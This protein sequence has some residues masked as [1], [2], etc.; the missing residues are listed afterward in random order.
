MVP[1]SRKEQA[2]RSYFTTTLFASV[3]LALTMGIVAL[4]TAPVAAATLHAAL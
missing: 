1:A 2:M 3:S 4:S